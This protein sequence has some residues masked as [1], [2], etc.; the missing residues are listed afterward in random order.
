[1][2]IKQRAINEEQKQTR[3]QIILDVALQLFQ[4]ATYEAV[5]MATVAEQ[6]K[7]AKGTLYLYFKT[8]EELFLALQTQAFERWFDQVD[9]GL[10]AMTQ[11]P[12]PTAFV[13]FLAGTLAAHPALVRLIAILHTTLEYN[14]DFSAALHFKQMLLRRVEQ[15]GPL[16]EMQLPF[17]RPGEGA[18]LLIHIHALVI[19]LQH[20]AEPAP[21][22]RQVLEQADLALFKI[23]FHREFL[24]MLQTLLQGLAARTPGENDGQDNFTR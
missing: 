2:S 22:V 5:S 10:R 9:A 4:E 21:L 24:S 18:Q 1:M 12:S 13:A 19:G 20:M 6:A 14:I 17:L 8:K 15:T 16:L 7:L 23:D 11:Q 3:R